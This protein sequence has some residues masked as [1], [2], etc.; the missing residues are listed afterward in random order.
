MQSVYKAIAKEQKK[1]KEQKQQQKAS[2]KQ[3]SGGKQETG[4]KRS[5]KDGNN[6]K[7]A[8]AADKLC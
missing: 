2:G 6:K 3:E 4:G 5:G 8:A 1:A 7:S